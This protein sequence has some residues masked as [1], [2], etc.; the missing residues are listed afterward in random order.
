MKHFILLLFLGASSTLI[1]RAS[2][3]LV[4]PF[5]HADSV[6]TQHFSS[7]FDAHK[8]ES[9]TKAKY[10]GMSLSLAGIAVIWNGGGGAGLAMSIVG[11][12]LTLGGTIGQ[13]IQLVRLGW[14]HQKKMEKSNPPLN[15]LNGDQLAC[16]DFD[17]AMGDRVAFST[18]SGSTLTGDIV[19]IINAPSDPSGCQVIVRYNLEGEFRTST[20]SPV[21]LSRLEE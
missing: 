19:G 12:I 7:S 20:L 8:L 14:K 2:D 13:D 21:S 17:L 3:L 9:S 16:F 11:A 4:E 10:F 1:L 15:T 6:V 18:T 5:L